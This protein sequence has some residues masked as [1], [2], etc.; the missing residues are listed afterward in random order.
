MSLLT[1]CPVVSKVYAEPLP[2]PLGAPTTIVDPSTDTDTPK[3]SP[4]A[5]SGA[6]S[7]LTN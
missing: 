5:P 4:P 2:E 1:N 6:V 3:L 7:L